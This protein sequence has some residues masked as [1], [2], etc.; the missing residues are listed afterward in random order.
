MSSL[1]FAIPFT[2][3]NLPD[4]RGRTTVN[5]N[6][7]DPEFATIGQKTGSKTEALTT[8]QMA[9]HTHIQVAHSHTVNDPGHNHSQNTHNHTTRNDPTADWI[10]LAGGDQ[11]GRGLDGGANN[12]I[13][14]LI[15]APT[16]ATN[17]GAYSSVSVVST[18]ATNQSTGS[19]ATH[20]NIQP[21][22]VKMSAIKYSP[23]DLVAKT[24][25]EGTSI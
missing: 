19:G 20:N 25:P 6:T 16:A 17:N 3:F 24:L 2:T 21:S 23:V 14:R 11:G 8:A 15:T 1:I 13:F 5:K 12:A 10:G 9:S 22:I 4:S 18:V 7:A